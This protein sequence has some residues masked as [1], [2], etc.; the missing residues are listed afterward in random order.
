MDDEEDDIEVEIEHYDIE[1]ASA[2]VQ[3]LVTISRAMK[4]PDEEYEAAESFFHAL[5]T[6][7]ARDLPSCRLTWFCNWYLR[8]KSTM[9]LNDLMF[10]LECVNQQ[11]EFRTLFVMDQAPY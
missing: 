4:I 7:L 3:D 10:F 5:E 8:L 9:P 2:L 11:S 1:A 6:L